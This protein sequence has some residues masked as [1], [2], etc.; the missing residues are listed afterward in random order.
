MG[1]FSEI[2]RI[3]IN[4]Y[5]QCRLYRSKVQ[6]IVEQGDETMSDK[7]DELIKK[8]VEEFL[9]KEKEIIQKEMEQVEEKFHII[10]EKNL[11]KFQRIICEEIEKNS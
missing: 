2:K 10:A 6:Y 7:F 9:R 8:A 1:R 11:E 5:K 3:N 4:D